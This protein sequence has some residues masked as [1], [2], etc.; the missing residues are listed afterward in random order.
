MRVLNALV[1]DLRQRI[2]SMRRS[3]LISTTLLPGMF[4]VIDAA[5][6][7]PLTDKYL[8]GERFN[9]NDRDVK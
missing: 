3:S 7:L 2:S 8:F 9:N 4:T 5:L 6:R 1:P